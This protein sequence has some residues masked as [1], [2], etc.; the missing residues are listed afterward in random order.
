[1]SGSRSGEVIRSGSAGSLSTTVERCSIRL[2]RAIR[3]GL[4]GAGGHGERRRRERSGRV[5]HLGLGRLGGDAGPARAAVLVKA[6]AIMRARRFELAAWE[7]Y[8]C[9]KPWAEADGDVAEAIDFCEFYAREMV[10]LAQ[11][12]RRDAPGETNYSEHIPRGVAVVIPPWNFPLAIPTGMTAAALVAGNTV[13]LKPAEQSPVIAWRLAEILRDAG[14]PAGAL[15]YSARPGR[16]S[17]SGAGQSSGRSSRRLHR[18]ARRRTL[19]QPPGR[20]D[21]ARAG[22]RETG[23]RRDGG[24]ER[25][26]RRRRCR[27]RRGRGWRDPERLRLRRAEVLGV[28]AR[29]RSRG[30]SCR[31]SDSSGR[32]GASRQSRAGRRSRNPRRP[33]DRRRC[34]GAILEYQRIAATEGT[35]VFQGDAAPTRRSRVLRRALDRRRR[36]AGGTAWP[37]KRSSVPCWLSQARMISMMRCESPRHSLCPHRRSLLAQPGQHRARVTREFRVG[38]LYINR[39]ITG[40]LVDRQPFGGF[41]LSGIGTKAGGPDY[42]LEFLLTRCVTENTMRRGFAPEEVDEP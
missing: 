28:L 6:A 21:F 29:D 7:T 41:K 36:R 30:N 3:R 38:N 42:L 9:G 18:V 27:P 20:G 23:Y 2:I 12:R 14:L 16:G 22:P 11:P 8:E 5:G 37:R 31:V 19:D 24:Q 1:M 39:P 15:N 33:A 35:I 34:A 40:A 10:R 13:I 25:D 17:R 4:S 32:G 26:H